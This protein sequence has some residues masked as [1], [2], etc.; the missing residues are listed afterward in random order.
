MPG[1]RCAGASGIATFTKITP[2]KDAAFASQT[3]LLPAHL[4][5]DPTS[6]VVADHDVYAS[7]YNSG[8]LALLR[9]R[10]ETS[11]ARTLGR[12]RPLLR[13]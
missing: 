13:P 5:L 1:S 8:K 2:I 3:N 6:G 7:I 4:G 11:R 10:N 12:E 9:T